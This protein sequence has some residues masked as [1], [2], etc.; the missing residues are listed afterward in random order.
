MH[1]FDPQT[2]TALA[3]EHA[4]Q[5]RSL[6]AAGQRRARI[7]QPGESAY[8]RPRAGVKPLMF[9]AFGAIRRRPVCNSVA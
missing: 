1:H 4:V 5:L 9:R 6:M 3:R 7:T 2:Q 8:I